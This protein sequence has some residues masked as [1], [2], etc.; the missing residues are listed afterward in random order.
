[1]Y[2]LTVKHNFEQFSNRELQPGTIDVLF[3][4]NVYDGVG[5][6]SRY[7][8]VTFQKIVRKALKKPYVVAVLWPK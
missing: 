1:M 5:E 6:V 2:T 4:G 7:L 3:D 8:Q